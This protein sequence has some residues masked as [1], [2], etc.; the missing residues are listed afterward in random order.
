MLR[1]IIVIAH[2]DHV[3]HPKE[4]D[5]FETVF[6]D[7]GRVYALTGEQ[8]KALAEDFATPRQLEDLFARITDHEHRALVHYFAEMMA[9]SDSDVQPDEIRTLE[10]L[11]TSMADDAVALRAIKA[12][13]RD[14]A[15][16][17]KQRN[18]AYLRRGT[19]LT[20]AL[21]AVMKRLGVRI[22]G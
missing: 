17:L 20:A 8:K 19:Q 15:E 9:W 22:T 18:Q 10:K 7:I 12:I 4:R 11:N 5:Y 2:A 16:K 3:I 6:S 14:I 1:C 21:Q 13:Q